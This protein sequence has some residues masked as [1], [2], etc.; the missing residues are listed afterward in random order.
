MNDADSTGAWDLFA[1]TLF[2]FKITK[3]SAVCLMVL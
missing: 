2:Y 1:S 3:D